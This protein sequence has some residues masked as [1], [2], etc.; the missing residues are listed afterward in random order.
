MERQKLA[1]IEAWKDSERRQPLLLEG[2]RQVGKTWLLQEFGRRHFE[3]VAYLNLDM[4]R[5]A[6]QIFATADDLEGLLMALATRSKTKIVPGQT[7]LILDEIQECPDALRFLKYFAENCPQLHVAAA[8]SLLRVML[9]TGSGFP[10]GKVDRISLCP[11]TFTEFL[12]ATG[13]AEL[14]ALLQSGQPVQI[15]P[16]H[17]VYVNSLRK[18]YVVGGMPGAVSAYL[19]EDDFEAARQVQAGILTDYIN[20]ISKHFEYGQV[21][22]IMAVWEAIPQF[23]GRENRRFV[24]GHAKHG[25]RA[26]DLEA[27]FLWLESAGVTHRVRAVPSPAWPLKSYANSSLFK[28][29]VLDVGL[30]GAMAELEAQVILQGDTVFREFKGALTEQ[31]VCQELVAATG[32]VPFYWSTSDSRAELDFLTGMG[33]KTFA[34]E[35]K[36]EENLRAKSL[37]VFS[38]KYP[39]AVALRFSLSGFRIQDWMRNVPLY[40]CAQTRLWT[41]QT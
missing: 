28:A 5:V 25:A 30:L 14:A 24:F 9:H 39:E 20:D 22:N 36:A 12:H 7:L 13:E 29:F 23:L 31:F 1:E 15:A 35:V 37:R 10:V 27:A 6:R 18:Y 41:N 16:F 19:S 21:A 4:D 11:M 38:E 3:H 26:K 32:M 17:D 2:A 33:G 8:G 34:I 40:A